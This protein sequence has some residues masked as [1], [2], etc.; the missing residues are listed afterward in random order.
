MTSRRNRPGSVVTLI[1]P[2]FTGVMFPGFGGVVVVGV[3][4]RKGSGG[5]FHTRSG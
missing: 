3:M 5:A 1:Y 2:G 4:L